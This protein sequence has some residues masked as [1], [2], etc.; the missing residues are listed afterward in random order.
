MEE[1]FDFFDRVLYV[2]QNHIELGNKN[3]HYNDFF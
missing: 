3:K 2:N 1:T